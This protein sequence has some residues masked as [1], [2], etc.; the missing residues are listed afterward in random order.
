M[1]L[2]RKRKAI[3]AIDGAWGAFRAP[4]TGSP[5]LSGPAAA[6]RPAS[7]HTGDSRDG[8]GPP[9]F[10]FDIDGVL[11]KGKKVLEQGRRALAKLYSS[12]GQTPRYPVCFLTNGGGVLEATKAEQLSS[13]L[14]V[15]VDPGQVILSHTPFKQLVPRLHDKTVLLS[16]RH[17]LR[18]V[19]ESYGFRKTVTTAELASL[20]PNAVPFARGL[21]QEP[22]SNEA[23]RSCGT[24]QNPIAAVLVFSDP[25]NWYIDLQL[26]YDVLTSGGVL[27]GPKC[28]AGEGQGVEIYFSNPD[29][30]FSNEFPTNRFGQGSLAIALKALLTEVGEFR[31][32]HWKVF[33]KPNPEPYKLADAVLAEQAHRLGLTAPESIYMVGDNPASDIAGACNTGRPW[34][35]IL[36][37]TGVFQGGPG[38]NSTQHPADLVVEDVEQAVLAGLHRGRSTKWHSLR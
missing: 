33:G 36:V 6:R 27:G 10:V 1:A 14:D 37:R 19:A 15:N 2:W 23:T 25:S 32:P 8:P 16:G 13:W 31:P 5:Q 34:R 20:H 3:S 28:T 9:A 24:E 38:G 4:V 26:I 29:Q 17:D 30:L 35:S 22:P 7:L 18:V 21:L 12:N 11:V